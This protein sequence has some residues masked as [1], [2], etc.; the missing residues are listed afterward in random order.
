MGTQEVSTLRPPILDGSNYSYW[1]SM[2]TIYL[3]SRQ[4]GETI[5]KKWTHPQMTSASEKD[6]IVDKPRDLW[7]DKDRALETANF[8]A[9]FTILASVDPARHKLIVIC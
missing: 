6:Q 7:D 4:C 5:V 3:R 8:T 1:K 2:M 9:L